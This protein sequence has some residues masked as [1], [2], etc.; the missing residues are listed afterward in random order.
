MSIEAP[1]HQDQE[2]NGQQS[3]NAKKKAAKKSHTPEIKIDD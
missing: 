3:K 2:T 1:V